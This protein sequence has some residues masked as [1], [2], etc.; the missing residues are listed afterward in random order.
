MRT[1][2]F[3]PLRVQARLNSE[4]VREPLPSAS[5]LLKASSTEPKLVSEKRLKDPSICAV[6]GW[7][8]CSVILP[9]TSASRARQAPAILPL[10]FSLLHADRNSSQQTWLSSFLSKRSRHAR[11]GKLCCLIIKASSVAQAPGSGGLSS[12]SGASHLSTHC[13]SSRQMRSEP[14]RSKAEQRRL[15]SATVSTPTSLSVALFGQPMALKALT[16]TTGN[17][18]LSEAQRPRGCSRRATASGWSQTAA[19]EPI[20][21]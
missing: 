13:K 15:G 21:L 10:N 3:H 14:Q 6:G 8:S 16:K 18:F 17:I 9:S 7:Y 4:K 19:H 2:P 12:H 5:K 11:R 20:R 1:S